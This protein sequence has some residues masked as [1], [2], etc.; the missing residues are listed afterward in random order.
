[1]PRY[2]VTRA[3][4]LPLPECYRTERRHLGFDESEM[5]SP[6]ARFYSP[7]PRAI[8]DHV[9]KALVAGR[10]PAEFGYEVDDV[11]LRLTRPGYEVLESGW[12]LTK[13]GTLLVACLTHMPGVTAAMWDWWF[14]WHS[15]ES[16]RYKLWHPGAHLFSAIGEDRSALP[17]LT[18]RQRYVGN[19]SGPVATCVGIG[20]RVFGRHEA[21]RSCGEVNDLIGWLL[22][23]GVP[24]VDL[25]HGDLS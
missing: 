19:V 16:A 12:A 13:Q 7:T 23:E 22:G 2:H 15:C 11:A 10:S 6:L 20:R 17:G 9:V 24:S 18:D 14:G 21:I 3:D 4:R 8:Q 1:M 5:Q 25:A